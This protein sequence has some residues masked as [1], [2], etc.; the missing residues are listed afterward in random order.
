MPIPN[1]SKKRA[2][3]VKRKVL[4]TGRFYAAPVTIGKKFVT[5][6]LPRKVADYFELSK[7]EIFWSPGD[8]VIQLSGSQPH[9]VIPMM[10]VSADKFIARK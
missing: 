9:V 10:S 3:E 1:T 2:K 6:K 7:P 8:G 4:M 5:V